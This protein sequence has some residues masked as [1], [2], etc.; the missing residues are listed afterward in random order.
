MKKIVFSTFIVAALLVFTQATAFACSCIEIPEPYEQKVKSKL[1]DA[2]AVFSGKVIEINDKPQSFEV[3][4][5]IK[6]ERLW[7]GNVSKEVIITTENNSGVFCG[8]SFEVGKS[9]LIYA[10]GSDESN[11]TTGLCLGNLQLQKAAEELK[12][13]GEGKKP[14]RKNG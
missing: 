4:V 5:K 13:L 1:N 9:Y 11:L 3:F 2:K 10:R 6:V 7:K 8:Y 14:R 12:I